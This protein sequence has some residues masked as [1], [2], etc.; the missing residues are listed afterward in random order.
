MSTALHRRFPALALP[1]IPL[2]VWPTPVRALRPDDGPPLWIKDDGVAAASYGGNKVRKLEWLLGD[3]RAQGIV[4]L[5]TLGA[6]GSHHVLATAAFGRA[7][8]FRTHAVLVPQPDT[9][10]V[11]ANARLIASLTDGWIASPIVPATPLAWLREWAAIRLVGGRPVYTI[12]AGGSDG[13]GTLGWV[14]A[15]LEIGED[16]AAGRMPAPKRVITAMGSAGT[17]GGLWLGLRLAGLDAEVIGVRVYDKIVTTPR[18]ARNMAYAAWSRL[19]DAGVDPGPFPDG[20]VNVIHDWFG[21]GYG[22]TNAQ[23]EAVMASAGALGLRPDVTYTAR[24]LGA[25][26]ARRDDGPTLL[27]WTLNAQPVDAWLAAAPAEVPDGLAGLL[28]SESRRSS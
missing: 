28:I 9:P 15:G 26:L 14:A 6:V 20:H 27:V 17:A 13:V 19:R 16:V 1:W 18:R 4:D 7:E 24:A 25:A 8:G 3:A 21:A 22:T 2:G 11:R 23:V 12:A 10:H 5:L